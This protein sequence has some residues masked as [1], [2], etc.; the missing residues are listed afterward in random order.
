MAK[1]QQKYPA[2]VGWLDPSPSGTK[3]TKK[4]QKNATAAVKVATDSGTHGKVKAK[5]KESERW[6]GKWTEEQ[7]SALVRLVM[8]SRQETG[9]VPWRKLVKSFSDLTGIHRSEDSLR[10]YFGRRHWAVSEGVFQT[11]YFGRTTVKADTTTDNGGGG[12]S[13]PT[14]A[15]PAVLIAAKSKGSAAPKAAP[16]VT[17]VLPNAKSKA[18]IHIKVALKVTPKVKT[19]AKAKIVANFTAA[20]AARGTKKAGT[21]PKAALKVVPPKATSTAQKI[22][23]NARS[24]PGG[25]SREAQLVKL[26][27]IIKRLIKPYPTS[28][29]KLFLTGSELIRLSDLNN[30]VH[31]TVTVPL[32]SDM[33]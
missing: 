29:H 9:T 11:Q 3:V 7:Q 6:T 5:A 1:K 24:K 22:I 4:Q 2:S 28:K 15:K 12:G 30:K 10:Q 18:A 16:K 26:G 27:A 8:E 13:G 20:A 14:A 21:A 33:L 17:V 31:T 19:A 32:T 25:S 23:I